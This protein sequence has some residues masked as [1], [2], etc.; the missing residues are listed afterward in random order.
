MHQ[1]TLLEKGYF[2]YPTGSQ[3]AWHCW[4]QRQ[5]NFDNLCRTSVGSLPT[6]DREHMHQRRISKLW[7]RNLDLIEDEGTGGSLVLFSPVADAAGTTVRMSGVLGCGECG[8]RLGSRA[9]LPGLSWT[10]YELGACASLRGTHPAGVLLALLLLR[11]T[12]NKTSNI[13]RHVY[14]I[15]RSLIPFRERASCMYVKPGIQ[16]GVEYTED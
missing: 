2:V 4:K 15:I 10:G 14:P 9:L 12:V 3:Q 7:H 8:E 5:C 16:K 1:Q 13:I 11:G 6:S